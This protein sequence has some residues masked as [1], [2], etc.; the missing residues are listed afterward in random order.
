[1]NKVLCLLPGTIVNTGNA[2]GNEELVKCNTLV[3]GIQNFLHKEIINNLTS[4]E[5]LQKQGFSTEVFCFAGR[6]KMTDLLK[7]AGAIASKTKNDRYQFVYVFWGGISGYITTLFSRKPVFLTLLGSDLLGTYKPDG[8]Q[9]SKGKLLTFFTGL[10]CNNARGII[11][12]SQDMRSKLP[13]KLHNKVL[14]APECIDLNKFYPIDK[15]EARNKL[16]IPQHNK[17][18]MFFPGEGRIVK[19]AAFANRIAEKLSAT[20]KDFTFLEIKNTPHSELVT[21]YNAADLLLLTSLHEGSN[22]S[23]KEAIACN[24]PVVSSNAG[25]A[26]ERLSSLDQ[27]FVINDFNESDY[28][29]AIESIFSTNKKPEIRRGVEDLTFAK[30]G[31]KI[32]NFIRKQLQI[33]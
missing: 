29:S 2:A 18:I 11:V 28:V 3:N 4:V 1:M 9:S 30:T 21:Y 19:N 20:Y 32:A 33:K 26:R 7:S 5:N 23:I 24:C 8:R 22:N 25:D 17:V 14:V 16:N 15:A 27:C 31:E 13:E 12:M 10:A 6:K